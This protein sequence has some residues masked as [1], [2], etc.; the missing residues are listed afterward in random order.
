MQYRA[1]RKSNEWT[2]AIR[3]VMNELRRAECA[4]THVKAAL[5]HHTYNICVMYVHTYVHIRDKRDSIN[6][7]PT[8]T[9]L[10]KTVPLKYT[11]HTFARM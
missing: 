5:L 3:K 1:H 6:V 7:I 2:F 11:S 10:I 8:R 9:R 4:R